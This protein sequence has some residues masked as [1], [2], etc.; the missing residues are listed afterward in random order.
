MDTSILGP[1]HVTDLY[2]IN[3]PL[4]HVILNIISSLGLNMFSYTCTLSPEENF[5]F[6]CV[7]LSK[8]D[9]PP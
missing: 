6:H 1:L 7:Y 2:M 8:F 9:V 5:D 4:L 3:I